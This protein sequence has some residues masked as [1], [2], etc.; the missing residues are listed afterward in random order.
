M[1]WPDR[2]EAYRLGVALAADDERDLA[3]LRL[4]DQVRH[5]GHVLNLLAVD[6][7]DAVARTQADLRC[8]VIRAHVVHDRRVP[9]LHR[10]AEAVPAAA[11]DEQRRE[12]DHREEEVR[13]RP[14][15]DD[16]HLLP[17]PLAPVRVG[18]EAVGEL[19]EALL[20]AA[21]RHPADV[22]VLQRL[23]ERRELAARAFHVALVEL[24]LDSVDRRHQL[25]GLF[26]RRPEEG[27]QVRR[28]RPVHSRDL[29]VAAE[30]DR[31]DAVLDALPLD[32][33]ERRR[34]ADV[35]APRAH[36]DRPRGEEVARLVDEDEQA[37]A[38][39]RDED[40]HGTSAPTACSARRRASPSASMSSSRSPAGAPPTAAR[41]SSTTPAIPR[42]GRRPARNAAT[43]T[44]F[45]AL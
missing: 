6:P 3:A 18:A 12:E 22:D 40:V 20:G 1:A 2:P 13:P 33:G 14:G 35:E 21:P 31:A 39:D 19:I 8:G 17:R 24:A 38:D 11:D 25:R 44:S 5:L 36:A 45:A 4:L 43:A 32:L 37:Q 9:R 15:K 10:E 26:E 23:G 29:H 30:R 7:Q 42:N 34:K 41:V 16:E 27:A 28:R